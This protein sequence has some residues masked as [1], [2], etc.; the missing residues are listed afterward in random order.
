M[1]GFIFAILIG[2]SLI[3]VVYTINSLPFPKRFFRHTTERPLKSQNDNKPIV[4]PNNTKAESSEYVIEDKIKEL[5][6][7]VVNEGIEKFLDINKTAESISKWYHEKKEEKILDNE[8]T[9]LLNESNIDRTSP[10][11]ITEEQK[12]KYRNDSWVPENELNN[13]EFYDMRIINSETWYK[14][15]P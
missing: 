8:I 10:E 1:E 11:K 12:E 3:F 15:T 13:R 14:L 4:S 5:H 2:L 6:E 7:K 9:T